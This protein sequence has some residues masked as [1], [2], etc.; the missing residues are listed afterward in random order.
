M[1]VS[2]CTQQKIFSNLYP[3][4]KFVLLIPTSGVDFLIV[5]ES[6]YRKF[7]KFGLF[8]FPSILT[9]LQWW[10]MRKYVWKHKINSQNI[11]LK[12]NNAQL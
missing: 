11:C 3:E 4:H 8:L 10:S 5:S 12:N 9:D 7:S 1:E 2:S 6:L